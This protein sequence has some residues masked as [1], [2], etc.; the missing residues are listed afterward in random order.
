MAES[1]VALPSAPAVQ[2]A[3]NVVLQP[4]LSHH[5]HGPGL[6]IIVPASYAEAQKH[7]DTLDPE[8]L[9]KWAEEGY[10]VVRISLDL[11]NASGDAVTTASKDLADGVKMGLDALVAL[12]ECDVKDKVGAIG[13]L[14][15]PRFMRVIYRQLRLKNK[16][17]TP[18]QSM[19]RER[20]TLQ[21]SETASVLHSP[22]T[23][24]S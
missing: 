14:P 2:L 7:N 12:P 6:L 24:I 18:V 16:M 22:L 15:L 23:R 4:P 20:T 21:T 11:N 10:A 13:M 9:Q 5:G 8:P 1:S 17:L 19:A 3:P